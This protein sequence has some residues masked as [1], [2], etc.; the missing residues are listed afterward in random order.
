MVEG[1]CATSGACV[2]F[3]KA[4][5]RLK[6]PCWG[7]VNGCIGTEMHIPVIFLNRWSDQIGRGGYPNKSV[8]G[9]ALFVA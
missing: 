5:V 8:H 6:A 2:L 4:T 7:A 1:Q 9:D 3:K